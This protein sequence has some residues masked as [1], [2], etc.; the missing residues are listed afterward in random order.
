MVV[1]ATVLGVNAETKKGRKEEEDIEGQGEI[2]DDG[3]FDTLHFGLNIFQV[4]LDLI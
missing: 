2:L 3:S 1:V 4:P